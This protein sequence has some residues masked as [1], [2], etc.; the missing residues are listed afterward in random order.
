MARLIGINPLNNLPT[1][2]PVLYF[3]PFLSPY[4]Y[5]SLIPVSGNSS[6]SFS[7]LPSFKN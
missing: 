6:S 3:I 5:L 7:S 1:L 2:A 4:R